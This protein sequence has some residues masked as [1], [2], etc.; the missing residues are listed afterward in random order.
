MLVI[1]KYSIKNMRGVKF[2]ADLTSCKLAKLLDKL[3]PK[4]ELNN[5]E[6]CMSFNI[7][8][9][10]NIPMSISGANWEEEKDES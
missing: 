8:H 10:P 5:T 3:F 6:G 9:L 7:I 2:R 4:D 1:E